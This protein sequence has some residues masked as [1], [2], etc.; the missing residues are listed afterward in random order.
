MSDK[1]CVFF[2]KGVNMKINDLYDILKNYPSILNI[3]DELLFINYLKDIESEK[4]KFMEIL[5]H[6]QD[7][8]QD[9]GIFEVT[10]SNFY[11]FKEYISWM[12]ELGKK[13]DL[14]LTKYLDGFEVRLI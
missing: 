11:I 2:Y 4:A 3:E 9:N 14:D 12:Q 6:I 13:L 7:S 8:H 5:S 1:I 10:D